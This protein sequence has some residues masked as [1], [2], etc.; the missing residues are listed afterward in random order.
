MIFE[1]NGTNQQGR[2]SKYM[3]QVAQ[4]ALFNKTTVT[5]Q[6][7]HWDCYAIVCLNST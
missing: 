4:T 6:E 2:M 5:I 3:W 7:V 1:Y